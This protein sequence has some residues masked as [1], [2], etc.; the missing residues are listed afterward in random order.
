M[1]K[2]KYHLARNDYTSL[3]GITLYINTLVAKHP[4]DVTCLNCRKYATKHFLPPPTE[5]IQAI[6]EQ[7]DKYEKLLFKLG[8]MINSP[9]FRCGYNGEGYFNPEIH[10]CAK[11]HHTLHEN[12]ED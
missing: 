9:C 4:R 3:C 12:A 7:L 1:R 6:K 5:N 2:Y 10:I 8:A 11:Y